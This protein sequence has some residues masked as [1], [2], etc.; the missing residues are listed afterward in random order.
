[1]IG[2]IFLD[3][4]INSECYCE[5]ILCTFIGHLHENEIARGYF[6]T[7]RC[8]C[9]H[10]SCFHEAAARCVRGQNNFRGNFATTVARTYTP[11]LLY[12]VGGGQWKPQFTKTIL[13]LS[14]IWRKPSQISSGIFLRLNRCVYLQTGRV[15]V[16]A[17]LQAFGG[18]FY[19]LLYRNCINAQGLS[20]N[21]SSTTDAQGVLPYPVQTNERTN[22]EAFML[23][24]NLAVWNGN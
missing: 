11:W 14:S 24:L 10:R 12:V 8:Y 22:F 16:D 20:E 13:T 6:Q 19:R 21:T 18:H 7:G 15:L 5:V 9:T 3:D 1:M 2:L 4:T 17:C 23:S